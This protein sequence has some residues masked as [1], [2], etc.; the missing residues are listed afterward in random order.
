[1][2]LP[3]THYDRASSREPQNTESHTAVS[4]RNNKLEKIS[5]Y[6]LLACIFLSPLIFVPS[7]YAPL[8]LV[9]SVLLVVFVVVSAIVYVLSVL[10]NR[11]LA[12][13]RSA[14][15][16]ISIGIVISTGISSL[17]ST[18]F[19]KSFIGQG[20][21]IGTASFIFLM[22]L[23]SFLVS[24]MVLRNKEVIFKIYTTILLSFGV[25][26]LIQVVR[27]TGGGN[28]L[29]FGLLSNITSTLIG[30]W[31]DFAILTSIAG[32]LS[33][34]GIKFLSMDKRLKWILSAVLVICGF[35]V[36]ITNSPIIWWSL[37]FIFLCVGI[38]EYKMKPSKAEGVKGIRS[39]ISVFTLI[40]L[41]I[42]SL[43]AWKG[44]TLSSSLVSSLKVQY[45]EPV[46]PWQLT[47]DVAANTLKEAPLF[48]AGP[49]R[50][51]FQYLR[52]KPLEVNQTPFWNSE[53][54]T[55]FGTLPTMVVSLGLVGL[56]LW[57][58][59]LIYFVRDG[60][61][62]LK[63]N[64][65]PLKSFFAVS[66]FFTAT[67]LWIMNIVYIPSHVIIFFTFVFTGI[68]IALTLA[69]SSA[70]VKP[71]LGTSWGRKIA[72][73][74]SAL[75]LIALVVWLGTEIKKTVAISYFQKGIRELNTNSN[76]LDFTQK[77]FQKALF[78]DK[79]DIYY[80]AL[81]EINII[82]INAITQELQASSTQNPS[83]QMDQKKVAQVI[84]LTN[85]AVQFTKNAEKLD[86]LNYYNYLA[87]AHISEV[88]TSLKIPNAYDNAKTSYMNALRTNPYSPSIYLSLAQL[89]ASQSKF[90][91]S[92]QYI[93]KALQL[94]Q[95]YTDAVY[96]LS[97]VQV[98]DGQLKDA[99]VSAKAATQ[100][101]PTE[102]VLF[103]QLGLLQYND[104][105]YTDAAAALEKAVSLNSQYANARYFLGLSY[106]RLGKNE[107]AIAQF[108]ELAKT[109]PDNQEVAFILTNLKQGKSPFADVKPPI[110]NKPE[111]RKTLPVPEK[112]TAPAKK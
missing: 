38:Y 1:M 8:D 29:T 100:I 94:K 22:F 84:T 52:F 95:N 97:Q 96:L 6:L 92:E 37:A 88:A 83:A 78:W 40:L 101:T 74:I 4:A 10:K 39:R 20:F 49:N 60:I 89:E 73:I 107:E 54:T 75:V 105:N 18:N 13:P 35:F 91:D 12:A 85:E 34:F 50:F 51:A 45:A 111:K 58:L 98:A 59:F 25:L 70:P 24:R 47:L 79:S 106:A 61:R 62:L 2:D 82:R 112:T 36:F 87:E 33:F 77:D 64:S 9:K 67:F 27:M 46:L 66:A 41:V 11:T 72:P 32:L 71:L 90:A 7:L 103:F 104:K 108:T 86:P 31:Y 99:I 30:K 109:N 44:D 110:D 102:P 53:F 80:Q 48:G 15:A 21:E 23:A 42:A 17:L 26:L 28:W 55:G 69:D 56:I 81:S 93:G 76:A 19:S 57:I 5:K 63:K 14:L 43:C 65:D 16:Y 68:C 3:T